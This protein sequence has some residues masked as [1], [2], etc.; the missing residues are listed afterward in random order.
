VLT[1]N[2]TADWSKCFRKWESVS[3]KSLTRWAVVYCMKDEQVTKEFLNALYKVAPSLGM[4]IKPPKMSGINDYRASTYLTSLDKVLE[5]KPELVMVVVPNNKGEH[6]AAIKKKLCLDVP[7]PS[8]VVTATV[9]NKPKGL[10]SV[11]TKVAVQMNCKL[12]GEPWAVKM[13]LKDTM[14]IGYDTYHDTLSKGRSV[15]AVVASLNDSMTKYVSIANI[16]TNSDQELHDNL[17]PAIVT[18]LRKYND[19]NG[20]LPVRIIIYRDGV[21]DGQIPYVMEHEVKSIRDT[22][23]RAGLEEKDLKFTFIVVSKKINT[24]ILKKEG[25]SQSNPPS[26]TIVDD[27]VTLPERYDFFLVSQ[28][29]NQGTVNPTSYNVIHDSSGLEPDKVQRLTYKLAHLYYNWPGTVRVPA[30]CQYAHKLAF[31]VGE[32]LHNTPKGGLEN[33]LYYL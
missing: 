24:K 23:L 33:N 30:P 15:G 19:V 17:C 10:M 26:G 29:V 8:Q 11:A 20:R 22:L 5:L 14:V 21:G 31:L 32:T 6:Y 28:S 18:A 4:T 3:G 1:C 16:H 12:G 13:P 9:L 25:T 2:L 27:V 7:T